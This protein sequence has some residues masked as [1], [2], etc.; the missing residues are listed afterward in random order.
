[1]KLPVQAFI[2]SIS[3]RKVYYFSNTQL[4][5]LVEHHYICLKR[6]DN[7][8]LILSC[9]TSKFETVKKYIEKN[10]LPY[11]TLVHISPKSSENPFTVDTYIN[12]NDYHTFTVEDFVIMH[13]DNK[14]EYTGE[15]S[16]ADYEQLL[17]GIHA[18]TLID[19]E[20]KDLLPKP[21][22]IF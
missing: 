14:L 2:D 9:C 1:M 16:L 12:C 15:V 10:N 19:E 17:Y 8:I 20:T 13:E 21:E 4:N 18:S 7:N 22:D 11:E 5:T 3:E 6:T